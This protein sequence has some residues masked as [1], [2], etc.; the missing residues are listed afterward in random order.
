MRHL[1]PTQDQ[2]GS[3][4]RLET[5]HESDTPL[6]SAMVLFDAVIKVGTLPDANGF[7]ITSCSILEPI[8]SIAG[9]EA[10]LH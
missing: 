9:E 2:T 8:S 7:Q 4:H 6:D 5:E 1:D 10:P 3:G